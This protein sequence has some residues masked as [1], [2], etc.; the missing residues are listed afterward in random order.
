MLHFVLWG[1]LFACVCIYPLF[2]PKILHLQKL[3][4][5]WSKKLGELAKDIFLASV[6][7]QSK[8]SAEHCERLW[9]D[10]E[11]KLAAQLQQAECTIKLQLED[12]RAQ[13]DKDGQVHTMWWSRYIVSSSFNLHFNFYIYA[14]QLDSFSISY[15]FFNIVFI[16]LKSKSR[17]YLYEFNYSKCF[18]LFLTEPLFL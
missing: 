14:W 2:L 15:L 5:S 8:L 1:C 10:L 17:G 6:P 7:A 3:R 9:L 11:Q 4:T 12:M 13:L 16:L 18:S